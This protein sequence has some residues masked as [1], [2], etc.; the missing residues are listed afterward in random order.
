M[1]QKTKNKNITIKKAKKPTRQKSKLTYLAWAQ[2]PALRHLR[3]IHGRHTGKI[4]HHKHTSHLTLLVI[5][6]ILGVFL[7][8]SGYFVSAKSVSDSQ[9]LTVTAV[10]PGDIVNKNNVVI[11]PLESS[12][13]VGDGFVFWFDTP[14]PLYLIIVML[15]LGFWLG[16]LFDRRFGT[17]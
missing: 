12:A 7:Y 6:L 15:T 10:V 13:S 3:L 1:S 5:L 8:A 2:F 16:D 4:V 11:K 14:V 9:S 17:R